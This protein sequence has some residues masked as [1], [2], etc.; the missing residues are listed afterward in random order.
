[1]DA[2]R[3]CLAGSLLIIL[4][5]CGAAQQQTF[6]PARPVPTSPIAPY[7]TTFPEEVRSDMTVL[8]SPPGEV[9]APDADTEPTPPPF[10]EVTATPESIDIP[11]PGATAEP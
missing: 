3:A 11:T 1:M 9:Q 2:R 7:T 8:E 6:V 4:T 10:E 5:G